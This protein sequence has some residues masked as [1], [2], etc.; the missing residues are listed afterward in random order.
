MNI[1]WCVVVTNKR[2]RPS[3]EYWVYVGETFKA[4]CCMKR[5]SAK[6]DQNTEI[7]RNGR[8]L[9]SGIPEYDTAVLLT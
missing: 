7:M 4:D 8:N 6:R 3:G 5:L 1:S 2:D 9:T